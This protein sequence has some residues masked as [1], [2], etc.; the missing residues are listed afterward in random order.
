MFEFGQCHNIFRTLSEFK[1]SSGSFLLNYLNKRDKFAGFIA[2]E[3]LLLIW[4][5]SL[6]LIVVGLQ[7]DNIDKKFLF[8]NIPNGKVSL[9]H[10]MQNKRSLDH[11]RYL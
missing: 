5:P 10:E 8:V 2:R 7:F 11:W 6:F 9:Q 1:T 4:L 3:L